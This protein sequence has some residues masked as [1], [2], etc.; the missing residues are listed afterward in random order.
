VF[1]KNANSLYYVSTI[2]GDNIPKEKESFV[3]F[4]ALPAKT[5][6]K[7]LEKQLF[8]TVSPILIRDLVPLR[9]LDLG[10]GICFF[11]IPNPG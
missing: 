3:R 10:S 11:R 8:K 4:P 2:I 7:S 6:E 5:N 1:L 9:P